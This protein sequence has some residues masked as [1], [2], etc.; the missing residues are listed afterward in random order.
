MTAANRDQPASD[1][2]LY[3]SIAATAIEGH[4]LDFGPLFNPAKYLAAP[5]ADDVRIGGPHH[6]L[7]SFTTRAVHA[8]PEPP[9][10]LTHAERREALR[11]DLRTL[12]ARASTQF[13]VDHKLLHATLN[14]RF[15]GPVATATLAG[16]EARRKL[17]TH[18]LERRVYDGMR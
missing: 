13:A 16:L 4:T 8:A 9:Q 5:P 2:G 6:A 15:G 7:G 17:I 11:R 10:E 18:W 12:V 1:E 14:Q 3:A